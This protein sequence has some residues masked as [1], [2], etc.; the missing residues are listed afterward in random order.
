MKNFISEG[1]T[2]TFTAGADYAAGAYLKVGDLPGI[3]ANA[4]ANGEE[5]EL[6]TQGVFELPKLSTDTPAVGAKAYWDAT[7]GELT[8]A[9]GGGA[10]DLIG[11][12]AEAAGNGDTVAKVRLNGVGV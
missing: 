4:V 7:P 1:R 6:V 3:V 8:T 5:G 11:T 9:D 10:N 12:F 2:L